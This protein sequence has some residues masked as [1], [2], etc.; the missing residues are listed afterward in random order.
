MTAAALLIPQTTADTTP[1]ELDAVVATAVRAAGP[2]AAASDDARAAWLEAVADALDAAR[3]ELVAI[4]ERESHLPT[5]RLT[6]EV[7]RTTGQLRLFAAVVRDGAYLEAVI[8]RARP[9]AT[10]PQPDLRRILRPLGPV[11][12]FSASNFPFAFSVAG[13][14]TASALAVG[15]PVVV[16]G[17]SGHPELSV[18]TAQVVAD[19]LA[20]AGAPDGVFGLV[21]GRPAGNALVQAPGIT[22]VGFTGSLSGGRALFDLACARPDPIP[23]YGE[24]GSINPVV[25]TPAAAKARTAEI[26]AG[27]AASFTLGVGQFCTK[28]GLVLVPAEAGF[29]TALAIEASSHRGGV[30]L[31]PRIAEAFPAGLRRLVVDGK[32]DLLIGNPG[33]DASDGVA[34]P[35]VLMADAARVLARPEVLLE[36]CFGPVTLLVR[37]ASDAERDAVLD[38]VGGSLTAT[39]HAEPDEDVTEL[40]ARLAERA[41]RVLFGGWPT[42]VAVTWSQHHG[43][44]WPATTSALH[45][46]VGATAVRRFQRPVVFQDAPASVL[47]EALRDE[48]PRSIVRR[49]DG[50]LTTAPLT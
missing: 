8:D 4:A 32:A 20:S 22:A 15:C 43:G 11:A 33:Q 47:P 10:P 35:A 13:G 14:D 45:T 19:A 44:P 34:R 50:E 24:L 23:F 5:L 2:S 1:E 36:E 29:E 48:N 41:G 12:V 17:H 7:A 27:L 42:G 6:G 21:L 16:K 40:A 28:P 37:Y 3:D 18:R 31:T 26:A 9:G 46:S 38:A 30:M 49:V 25:V 39:V